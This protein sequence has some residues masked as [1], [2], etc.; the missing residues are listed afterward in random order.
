MSESIKVFVPYSWAVE[1]DTQIIEALDTLCQQ[2]TLEL[3]RDRNVSKHGEPIGKLIK[4]LTKGDHVITVFTKPNFKSKWCLFELL[5]IYQR[6]D[7][8]QR[9]PPVIADDCNLQDRTN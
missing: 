6:G 8:K 4:E 3:I 5:H 2:R 7:F 9:T 1:R